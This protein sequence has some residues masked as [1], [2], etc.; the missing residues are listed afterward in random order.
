MPKTTHSKYH[1][2]T[3]TPAII[4]ACLVSYRSFFTRD[5]STGSS[6]KAK[7][8]SSPLNRT[9][10]KM[11]SANTETTVTRVKREGSTGALS[12]TLYHNEAVPLD[13]IHVRNEYMV[14]TYNAADAE[15]DGNVV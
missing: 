2:L 15:V 1:D 3:S 9:Y 5:K 12:S 6:D 11:G 4:I 8:G 13:I 7:S 10:T 14:D